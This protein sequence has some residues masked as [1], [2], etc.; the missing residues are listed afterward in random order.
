MCPRSATSSNANAAAPRPGVP[1]RSGPLLQP[2]AQLPL[3]GERLPLLAAPLRLAPVSPP[4]RAAPPQRRVLLRV[5]AS[6]PVPLRRVSFVRASVLPA[7][8]GHA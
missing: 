1:H 2:V 6:V 8:V 7:C 4:R 3:P 5:R